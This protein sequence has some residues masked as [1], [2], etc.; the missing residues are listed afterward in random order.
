MPSPVSTPTGFSA[1]LFRYGPALPVKDMLK[2]CY[3]NG[4]TKRAAAVYA[5]V[6]ADICRDY[7]DAA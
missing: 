1:L 3:P 5:T 6:Y 4:L 2:I 7:H